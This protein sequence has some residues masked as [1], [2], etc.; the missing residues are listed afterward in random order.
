[1]ASCVRW[2]DRLKGSTKSLRGAVAF[3]EFALPVALANPFNFKCVAPATA[4]RSLIGLGASQ[5]QHARLD[6]E[7]AVPIA[8]R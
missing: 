3:D 6:Q 8:L 7:R 2:D 4:L 1:M 5:Q